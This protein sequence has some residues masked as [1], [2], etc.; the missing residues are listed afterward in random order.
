MAAAVRHEMQEQSPTPK[1]TD[2]AAVQ[3]AVSVGYCIRYRHGGG[4]AAG[5]G[6]NGI[7][8]QAAQGGCVEAEAVAAGGAVLQQRP[9]KADAQLV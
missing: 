5:G 4:Q 7:Q 9:Q 8:L 6:T 2:A 1:R 3:R